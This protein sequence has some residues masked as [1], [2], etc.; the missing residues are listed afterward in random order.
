MR[1]AA[2]R[3]GPLGVVDIGDGASNWPEMFRFLGE[4]GPFGERGESDAEDSC[5]ECCEG[6]EARGGWC[7][8]A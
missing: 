4:R 7:R 6:D 3:L 8:C 2:A 5:R 1:T